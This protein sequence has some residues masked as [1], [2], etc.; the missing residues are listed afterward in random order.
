VMGALSKL[1][2]MTLERILKK[3]PGVQK[4]K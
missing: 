3:V 1:Q 2:T 4:R